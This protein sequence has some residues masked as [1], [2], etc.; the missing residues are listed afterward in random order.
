MPRRT[1]PVPR[2]TALTVLARVEDFVRI[3][4]DG[5]EFWDLR[6][7]VREKEKEEG[8]NWHLEERF[9][10]LSDK[11]LWEYKSR[12]ETMIKENSQKDRET[13]VTTGLAKR[14]N[15][16]AKAVL[17]G[18]L[19][20]ALAC[21]RDHDELA[22]LYPD[23]KAPPAAKKG[24]HPPCDDDAITDADDTTLDVAEPAAQP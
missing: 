13:L 15:L 12:A 2:A 24:L 6:E 3:L 18:D 22:G 14:R 16:Y 1:K 19:R 11:M 10:P 21:I 20:T 8:S 4:L 17:A 7:F 23:P 5:A 9:A